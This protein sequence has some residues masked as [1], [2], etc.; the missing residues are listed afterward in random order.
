MSLLEKLNIVKMY[1]KK[2]KKSR[3]FQ[4][5][6]FRKAVSIFKL[7]FSSEKI[8]IF[9]VLSVLVLIIS[10][11]V[12]NLFS[13]ISAGI[14]QKELFLSPRF[15]ELL[16][17]EITETLL[18]DYMEQNPDLRIRLL[19]VPD[20]KNR[21]PDILIFDEG[22]FSALVAGGALLPLEPYS[23]SAAGML[24]VPLVSFMDMLFFNIELLRTAG[25]DRPPKTREEFLACA[26]AAAKDGVYGA[27]MALSPEDRHSLSR[28]IFSWIWASGGDFWMNEDGPAINNRPVIRDIAF[29]GSLNQGEALAPMTFEATGSQ[30]LDEFARGKLAMMIA[31]TK[32]IPALREK[33][34]DGAFGITTIPGSGLAGKYSIGLSC[35]YAGINSNCPYPDEAWNFLEFLSEHSPLFCAELKA[36]PGIVSDLFSGDYIRDDPFYSK[37]R[38]IFE[39]SHIVRGF[40][41]MADAEKFEKAVLEEMRVFFES[42][43]TAEQTAAAIQQRWDGE[44]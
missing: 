28:D 12:V 33:M 6:I 34:G 27:A 24:A 14:K 40:S 19:N 5:F 32:A 4:N 15:E 21:E 30:R 39:A 11:L 25:F 16:G 22:D 37:A 8:D 9:L 35:L 38:D 41:G 20:E 13:G 7:I 23:E 3:L 43:R 26:K 42:G 2:A 44:P 18:A 1:I 17:R 36:V 29:L 31:S 10:P